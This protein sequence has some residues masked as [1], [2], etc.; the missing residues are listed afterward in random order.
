MVGRQVL[1]EPER[2]RDM[3]IEQ[4]GSAAGTSTATVS[5]F[6]KSLG[7]GSYRDF[8]LDLAAALA[9]PEN[10]TLDDF[11]AGAP[12]ETILRRVF[13]CNRLSLAETEKI[14]DYGAVLAV[15]ERIRGARKVVF[16]GIGGSGLVAREGA[17]RFM[18][19]GLDAV[20]LTDP[21]EQVF[22]TSGVN[23]RDVVFGVSHTGETNHVLEALE[24]A[25][26]R[27]ACTVALTNYPGSHLAQACDFALITAFREHRINAAVSSSRIAQI[28]VLDGLYFLVASRIRES[29]LELAEEAEKRVRQVLRRRARRRADH[30]P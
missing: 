2:A 5:R 19:L 28:C 14:L 25:H 6:C 20:A 18:S 11:V 22:V 4:L 24:A 29:A 17:Q 9:Q 26:K 30:K 23:R 1:A 15:A 7:Y 12:P 27:N 10:V 8:Q 21:Y 13:E 3:S 16:L